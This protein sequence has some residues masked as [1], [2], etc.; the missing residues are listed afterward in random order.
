MFACARFVLSAELYE[1]SLRISKEL[2]NDLPTNVQS[3][4]ALLEP[5]DLRQVSKI[6]QNLV[7]MFSLIAY[8]IDSVASFDSLKY[9][10]TR[11]INSSPDDFEKC[12]T[13][14]GQ[15]DSLHKHD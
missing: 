11:K 9:Y 15:C 8:L 2:T 1:I 3:W 4:L 14:H 13:L 6:G 10:S 5:D 12:R 7:V